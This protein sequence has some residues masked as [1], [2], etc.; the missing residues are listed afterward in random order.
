MTRSDSHTL[1]AHSFGVLVLAAGVWLLVWNE[2]HA[3]QEARSLAE[4]LDLVRL[5]A[6]GPVGGHSITLFASRSMQVV[7]VPSN[8]VL[9]INEGSVRGVE[10]MMSMY[11]R[12]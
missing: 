10:A 6:Q 2:G 1:G 5:R 7:S 8:R 3:V 11:W 4:G 12:V 9:D